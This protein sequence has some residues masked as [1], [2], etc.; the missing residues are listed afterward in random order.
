MDNIVNSLR[1]LFSTYGFKAGMIIVGIIVIVNFI[2]KPITNIAL[3]KSEQFGYDKSIITRYISILPIIVSFV[4][5]AFAELIAVKF[6]FLKVEWS[7]ITAN[8]LVYAAIAVATYETLKKQLQAYAAKTNYNKI[9]SN[10]ESTEA[11]V[12]AEIVNTETESA[13]TEKVKTVS[14]EQETAVS[15]INEKENEKDVEIL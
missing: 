5:T 3:K 1:S 8:S 4:L 11:T 10:N 13:K 15:E 6:Q 12:S 7:S 2:K 9:E 14:D